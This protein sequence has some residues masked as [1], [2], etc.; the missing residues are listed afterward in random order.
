[1]I[2]KIECRAI[3]QEFVVTVSKCF[4]YGSSMSIHCFWYTRNGMISASCSNRFGVWWD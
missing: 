1:M 3:K 2:N 4:D